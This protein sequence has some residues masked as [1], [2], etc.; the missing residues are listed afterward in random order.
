MPPKKKGKGK[1]KKG[2]DESES[3][4]KLKQAQHET[5]ALKDQMAYRRELSRRS[6]AMA[7]NFREQMQAAQANVEEL[8]S[9]MKAVSSGL[10]QQYKTMQMELGLKVTQ[11]ELELN[12][13]KTRLNSTEEE[14]AQQRA[15]YDKMQREKDAHIQ[16]I[17]GKLTNL[18]TSFD[19]LI[20]IGFNNIL[21]R[22]NDEKRKWDTQMN[23]VFDENKQALRKLNLIHLEV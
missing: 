8:Q 10:T 19:N 20:D 18:E 17:E 23:N 11:L 21:T 12:G 9:D 7:E 13:T 1:K 3:E 16:M 4:L 15:Q 22:L 14:L 6:M 5:D 2:G